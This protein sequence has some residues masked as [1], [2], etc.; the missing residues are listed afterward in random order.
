MKYDPSIQEFLRTYV[1]AIQDS[2]AS[3]FAGAGLSRPAGYVDW[4]ELLREVAEDLQLDIDQEVDLIALAQYHVNEFNGRSKINQILIDEFTR[5]VTTTD[6]HKI[7]SQLPISTYWTTNYDQLIESNLVAVGKKVDKKITPENLSYSVPGSDAIVYKMHGD[8][9]L[10]HDA[11]L[12]KDDYEGYDQ[13]RKLFG[14][15]LRGD[16]VSKTFL[17]IG[18]SFD[19]PNLSQI[20]SKIRIL[21]NENARTHYCFMKKVNIDDYDTEEEFRYATI[22]QGLKIKDLKRYSIK[23]LLVD[24]Y[25]EVTE[26]LKHIASLVIRK[27]IFVSGSASDYGEWGE[28]VSFEFSTSLSKALIKNNNNIVSGFGLGL[29]SCIVSGALEE[30]YSGQN[31]KVEERLKCRPFPQVTTGQLS[32]EQLWTKYRKEMLSNVGIAVFIFGNKIDTNTQEIIDANGMVE[33]FDISVGNGAIPIPVGATGFTSKVLWKKVMD[34]FDN[35]VGIEELKPLYIEL[36][37]TNKTPKELIE[38]VIKIINQLAK[39]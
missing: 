39:H 7:L 21:L 35:Y 26:I 16:L 9:T 18:F 30:L 12:T 25:P 37:D 2:N 11:V 10:P 13:K 22:K 29:G 23:V 8:S 17:F 24:D 31:N 32:R 14:T 36:G 1:K 20:L 19:D 6:N 3:I 38:T 28:K 34:D 15:A 33:E 5:S 27:N 4:K